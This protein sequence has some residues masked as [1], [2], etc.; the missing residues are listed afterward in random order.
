MT[1]DTARALPRHK[2]LSSILVKPAGPDCNLDCA[3][4]FYAEKSSLFSGETTRRMSHELLEILI[5]QALAQSSGAINFGWQGGEPTLMGLA[6][7]QKAVE[8]EERFQRG[9]DVGNGLQTNGLLLNKDWARFLCRNNF[10]VGLSLDGPAHVHDHYRLRRGGQG[11]WSEVC[12]RAKLL[13]DCGVMVNA[14]TVISDHSVRYP[15]EIYEFHKNMGLSHMQFIPCLE[16]SSRPKKFAPSAEA[17]GGFWR[18]LFDL[19]L[20]DFQDGLATTSVRFFDSVFFRYVGLAPPEC[21]LQKNCGTYLVVEH[22]GNVYSCDFFVEPAWGLGNLKNDLLIDML[23]SKQQ[24]AFG[25]IKS[26][27]AVE[28]KKCKWLKYCQGGCPAERP[29]QGKKNRYCRSYRL[30]FEHA[31]PKLQTLARDWL[32]KHAP[33]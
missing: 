24:A 15:E 19:W 14:L 25:K 11:S 32:A 4:C 23:N 6:F 31:H 7:F 33:R 18:R 29:A 21:T 13:L 17:L 27:L 12:D 5:K 20:A 22:N 30:F 10:L 28:C 3:Y 8:L 1:R 9:Q 2:P 16:T 26:D